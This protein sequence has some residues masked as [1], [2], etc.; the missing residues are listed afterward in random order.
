MLRIVR[1]SP[2]R[3]KYSSIAERRVRLQGA[4]QPF[5]RPGEVSMSLGLTRQLCSPLSIVK[6]RDVLSVHEKPPRNSEEVAW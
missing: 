1:V 6:T 3:L 4:P 2:L 5:V